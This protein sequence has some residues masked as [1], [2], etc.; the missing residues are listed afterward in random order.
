MLRDRYIFCSNDIHCVSSQLKEGRIPPKPLGVPESIALA[1]GWR[2]LKGQWIC[3][4]C[5]KEKKDE[6]RPNL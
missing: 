4:D 2:R 6:S 1:M 5:L 3:P